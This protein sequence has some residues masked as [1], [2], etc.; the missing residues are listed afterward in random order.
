MSLAGK[1][2]Q[3]KLH[4]QQYS[5]RALLIGEYFNYLPGVLMLMIQ[6]G[7]HGDGSINIMSGMARRLPP[8]ERRYR[9]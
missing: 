1:P 4:V 6:Q 2:V 9:K 7:L 5:A 3:D 8:G